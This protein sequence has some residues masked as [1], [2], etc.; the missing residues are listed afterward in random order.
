MPDTV[1]VTRGSGSGGALQLRFGRPGPETSGTSSENE[2][3]IAT[4]YVKFCLPSN[5][6]WQREW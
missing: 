6:F 5:S 1:V 2:H 3:R 4:G